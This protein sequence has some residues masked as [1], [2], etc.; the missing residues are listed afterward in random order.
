MNA[1][2][3]S[4]VLAV[5]RLDLTLLWRNRTSLFT[6]IGMPLLFGGMLFGFR[7]EES[8][9]RDMAL[10]AGT[11]YLAFFLIFAV[12]MNLVSVFTARREDLTLKRLRSGSLS[13]AEVFGGSV[14]V[15]GAIYLLQAFLLVVVLATVLDGPWPAN[16]PLMLA[17]MLGGIVVFALLAFAVSGLTPNAD[18]A[19]LTVVPIMFA[20]MAGSGVMF[21]LDGLPEA[22]REAAGMLPLSPLV[23]IV[24]TGYFGED[25]TV[26]AARSDVGFTEAW[27]VSLKPF[28]VFALWTAIGHWSARRW[29]RWEPRHA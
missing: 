12:F 23:D 26:G 10:F 16:P 5:A 28:A 29:F 1:M 18:L 4:H 11:G 27:A 15:S 6:V 25:H 24:R 7:G 19:Q 20:S 22:A 9:G 17:G 2:N 8:D 21:P 3:P 13:D 14:A